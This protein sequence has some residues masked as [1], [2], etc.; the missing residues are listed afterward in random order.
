MNSEQN[1]Q[2]SIK[3]EDWVSEIKNGNRALLSKGITLIESKLKKDK[4]K[5]EALL[6][7][8]APIGNPASLRISVTGAPGVGKSTF[9]ECLGERWTS[10][11]KK[12]AVLAVDPSSKHSKGSILGDKT[13]MENLGRHPLAFIRP[14]PS[15]QLLG[16]VNK[17]TRE[18]ILLCELAGFDRI[19][20]ETVGVGQSETTVSEMVDLLL[21]L[22]LPGAGDELQGIKRGIVETADMIVIHKA[23]GLNLEKVKEAMNAYKMALHLFPLREDQWLPPVLSCSS[24]EKTGFEEIMAQFISFHATIQRKNELLKK[25]KLQMGYWFDQLIEN[26][27][28]EDFFSLEMTKENYLHLMQKVLS[29]ELVP[30]KALFHLFNLK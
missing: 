3:I 22:L 21:L 16:G 5:A 1:F 12:V 17:N 26:K 18:A 6:S 15:G 23:D 30:V 24:L 9:I 28:R 27:L 7:Y 4:E 14:S 10:E 20:V 25:R 8:C 29:G 13:R 19:I 11:G 2:Q